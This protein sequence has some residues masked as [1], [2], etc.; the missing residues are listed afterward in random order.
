[1]KTTL[2]RAFEMARSGDYPDT[3]E[4]KRKLLAE[5]YSLTQMVGPSLHRQLK[6]LCIEARN[7]IGCD[8]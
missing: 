1:M 5:G 4:L 6:Q 3:I 2:E 7:K 8:S